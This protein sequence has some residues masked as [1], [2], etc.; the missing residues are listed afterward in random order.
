MPLY[1]PASSP[2]WLPNGWSNGLVYPNY[3]CDFTDIVIT[4]VQL[5]VPKTAR[6]VWI[7]TSIAYT[8]TGAQ[9]LGQISGLMEYF[10]SFTDFN[11][12]GAELIQHNYQAVTD[13]NGKMDFFAPC[14]MD[15]G[16][17]DIEF[18]FGAGQSPVNFNCTLTVY[19]LAWSY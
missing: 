10:T 18:A 12:E 11:A 7:E 5:G 6:T 4:P 13:T 1:R 16:G 17:I 14:P 15:T 8:M 19:C 9:P 2:V 3:P